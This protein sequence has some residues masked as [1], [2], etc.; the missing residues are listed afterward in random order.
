M[1]RNEEGEEVLSDEV[2]SRRVYRL[3][4]RVESPEE[5]RCLQ[6]KIWRAFMWRPNQ[7]SAEHRRRHR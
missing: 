2:E 6:E 4:H 1:Q 3:L 5:R 7:G